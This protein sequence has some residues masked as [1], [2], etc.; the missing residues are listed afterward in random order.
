MTSLPKTVLPWALAG[1]LAAGA[2]GSAAEATSRLIDGKT[3]KPGTITSKH[4]SKDTVKSFSKAKAGAQGK[5]GPAGPQGPAGPG[6][7]AAKV[8]AAALGGHIVFQDVSIK[9][10]SSSGL[11]VTCPAGETAFSGGAL[12]LNLS[13]EGV[14][15]GPTQIE[16]GLAQA[17]WVEYKNTYSAN[18]HVRMSALCIKR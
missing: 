17:W 4:L 5:P 13:L 16:N 2:F 3:I 15:S 12:G 1:V 8:T 9:P 18:V 11:A 6:G 10:G 14:S 7:G